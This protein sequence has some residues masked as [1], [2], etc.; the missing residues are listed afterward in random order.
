MSLLHSLSHEHYHV[1]CVNIIIIK[2]F[3][4]LVGSRTV[5]QENAQVLSR[6]AVG[7]GVGCPV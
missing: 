1:L 2:L 6:S 5:L 7:P 4:V 3:S